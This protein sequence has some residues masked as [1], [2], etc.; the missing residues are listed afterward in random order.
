MELKPL[1][2]DQDAASKI[3]E[4]PVNV[5]VTGSA[6]SGKSFLVRRYLG[7]KDPKEYPVLAS[8]GAAAIL[9]GGRTFHS[10]FGLGIMQGGLEATVERAAKNK[11]L[12]KRL[13][14]TQGV[15]ID[16]VSMLPGVTI[17]AAETISRLAREKSAP[18]GGLRV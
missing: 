7:D 6:G 10:F 13:R 18:W 9:V 2:S 16:E 1:T 14:A 17:R 12:V 8:T 3:L 4:A 15:V 5:F 11:R